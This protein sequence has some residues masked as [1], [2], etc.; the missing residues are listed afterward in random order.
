[1]AYLAS[2]DPAASRVPPATKAPKASAAFPAWSASTAYERGAYLRRISDI[3]RERADRLAE[4]TVR[5]SGK[6][7]AQAKGEWQVA[8]DLFER[9]LCLPS[10]SGMSDADVT[11]T[12]EAVVATP[13]ASAG[14]R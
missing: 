11:R 2:E 3:L 8:A 1:M 12:V 7:L 4:V 9:G 10:G 6:P 13:G 14:T 5:E